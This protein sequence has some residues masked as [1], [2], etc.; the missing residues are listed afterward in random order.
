MKYKAAFNVGSQIEGM[1][2]CTYATIFDKNGEPLFTIQRKGTKKLMA[3]ITQSGDAETLDMQFTFPMVIADRY[4][5]DRLVPAVLTY[6]AKDL[7][8]QYA[9]NARGA[10]K[11]QYMRWV[12]DQ[13]KNGTVYIK[14]AAFNWYPLN[15]ENLQVVT[16]SGTIEDLTAEL[17]AAEQKMKSARALLIAAGVSTAII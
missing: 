7:I 4:S 16:S 1:I 10:G 13:V 17:Q 15:V 2:Q 6:E 14:P 9:K 8:Y 3:A 5:A 12:Y 11:Q